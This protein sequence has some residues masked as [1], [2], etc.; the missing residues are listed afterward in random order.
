VIPIPLEQKLAARMN[1]T[2]I[3]I[4]SSHVVMLA[5]PN[6]VFAFIETALAALAKR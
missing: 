3:T 5:H 4:P 6:E 1:A 2:T